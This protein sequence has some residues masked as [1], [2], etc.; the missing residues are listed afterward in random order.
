MEAILATAAVS[1]MSQREPSVYKGRGR[2]RGCFWGG[3]DADTVGIITD[4]N[5]GGMI[6][7]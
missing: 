1:N 7:V 5:D 2:E 3:V 6:T 4:C